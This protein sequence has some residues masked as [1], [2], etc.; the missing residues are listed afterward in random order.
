MLSH[1]AKMRLKHS[2]DGWESLGKLDVLKEF[3]PA[4]AVT[5][6]IDTVPNNVYAKKIAAEI[7]ANREEAERY[8]AGLLGMM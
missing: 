5:V 2:V 4:N 1:D 6:I 8:L 7:E 3:G